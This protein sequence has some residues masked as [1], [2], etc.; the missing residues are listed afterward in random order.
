[1]PRRRR[2]SSAVTSLNSS[3]SLSPTN[4]RSWMT[5]AHLRVVITLYMMIPAKLK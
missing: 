5:G 1:V 4:S 3:S 2:A